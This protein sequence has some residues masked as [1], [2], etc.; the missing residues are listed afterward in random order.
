M[1][2]NAISMRTASVKVDA[3]LT[4]EVGVK[5]LISLIES[6]YK[7]KVTSKVAGILKYVNEREEAWV[8]TDLGP[9]R[10]FLDQDIIFPINAESEDTN[11]LFTSKYSALAGKVQQAVV[12]AKVA[13]LMGLSKIPAP[14]PN[15]AIVLRGEIRI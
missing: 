1:P 15:G 7:T 14:G 10:F 12:A 6:T 4:T 9:F 13:K 3:I 2:C 11:E 8:A 5:A